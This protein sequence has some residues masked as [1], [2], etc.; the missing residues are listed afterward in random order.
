VKLLEMIPSEQMPVNQGSG[1]WERY[2]R[3]VGGAATLILILGIYFVLSSGKNFLVPLVTAFIVVYFVSIINRQIGRLRLGDRVLPQTASRIISFGVIIAIGYGLFAIIANNAGHVA[4]AAPR[5][6]ARLQQLQVEVFS[7]IGLEEPPELRDLVK[8]IDLR[9]LFT[10]VATSVAQLLESITL[11]FIYGLFMLLEFRFA[12]FKLEALFPDPLRR[13]R[14]LSILRRIDHD[15]HT[16]LGVKTA[17][18][19]TTALLSYFLLR[20]VGL[21]FAEF[22]ALL[23]FIL[24]FIPTFGVVIATLLPTVLAAVQFDHLG[25][26][27]IVGLGLTAIAQLMGSIVEPNVMGESLN[28]S[29]LAVIMALIFWGTLWGVTGAFLCVPLTVILVIAL[30]NFGTTRWVAI[31]LSKTGTIRAGEELSMMPKGEEIVEAELPQRR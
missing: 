25:P 28:L 23:I 10:A 5:Y 1:R 2:R 24:H 18:S 17:V 16:Y 30:S 7:R 11:V 31:L 6:Q 20:L 26:F 27:L 14:T 13:E 4:A 19:L 12:L 3:V 29:P 8:A 21:D 22:W 9:T 15:I